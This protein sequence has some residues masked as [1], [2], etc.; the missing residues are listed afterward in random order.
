MIKYGELKLLNMVF[1]KYEMYRFLLWWVIYIVYFIKMLVKD[2]D[3]W[4][5]I[6]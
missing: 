5:K 6:I 2:I 1:L 4:N 3:L